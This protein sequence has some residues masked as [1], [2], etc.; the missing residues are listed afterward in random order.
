[1]GI[2]IHKRLGYGLTD[3]KAKNYTILDERFNLQDGYFKDRDDEDT[4]SIEGLTKHLQDAYESDK[5]KQGCSMLASYVGELKSKRGKEQYTSICDYICHDGEFGMPGVVLFSCLYKDWNR[6]D[7]IIDYVE[8]GRVMKNKVKLLKFPIYPYE[9]GI[10]KDTGEQ[11]F[12]FEGNIHPYYHIRQAV[13]MGWDKYDWD[14]LKE[15]TGIGS[16]EEAKEKIVPGVP[17]FIVE[18]CKYL[19]VFKDEKTVYSLKP[20]VYTY[21]S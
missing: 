21:W 11:R 12:E 19:K 17:E 2:R 5:K 6:Y 18:L 14:K 9:F 1:M 3:V 20:M 10:N 8:S 4:Y 16:L 7:D 15:V 13:E